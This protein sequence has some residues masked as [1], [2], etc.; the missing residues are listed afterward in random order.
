MSGASDWTERHRPMS[1]HQLE[2]NEIQRRQIREWL[3]GWVAGQPKKKGILL[4]GPPGVGKTTVARAIAHDMGWTVIE[5]NAS[6]SRNAVA[7]RKAATQGSTHRSLFHDPSKPQQRTLILLDE[8]DH[9]GG[10]LRPV[11]EDR[12]R[13]EIEEDS[14]SLTGDSG[15]KAELLRLLEA[16]KQP[17]ILACNDIM[18][19]WG[20]SSSTWRN[21]KDRFSKHLV[22]INFDRVSNEALRRIARRVLREE[23][24]DFTQD[25]IESL[26]DGNHGDLRALVRDL[27]VLS[28]G[29]ISSLTQS[30]VAEHL[31]AGV[32]DVTTEVFPGMENLYRSRTAVEAVQLGRTIDKQPS[33]LMNWVHWNNSSLFGNDSIEKAS[34]ALIVADKSVESRFRDLAHHSSYWTLHL[35]SLSAS[36]ANS[37]PLEGRIYASYPHYLRR[38]GSWTRPAIISHLSDMSKTSKSTVRR[39]FLPL[40]SAL[41]R[42]DSVIGDPNEFAISHSLGL[43]SQEHATLCNMPVSRKSTKAMM[44]AFDE[45][46]QKWKEPLIAEIIDEI[47]VDV[48]VDEVVE[49]VVEEPTIDSAQRT[50]F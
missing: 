3:D 43:S 40:L 10:G 37:K 49:A 46:E 7:I 6:D 50:L 44:K 14:V 38:S 29:S 15:G 22:T 32:R 39:E 27:Q 19:L 25:A 2:G 8:V 18:G 11:S 1:E 47:P 42:E 20:R 45:A 26:I 34:K 16:T 41:S 28:T 4:V 23:N 36:V 5:L 24:I 48:E 31:E 9:I 33:D 12:I 13:K 21:T 17:V 30:Q 35:S